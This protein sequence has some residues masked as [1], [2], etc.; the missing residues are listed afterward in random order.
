MKNSIFYKTSLFAVLV[1]LLIVP[2][3][4]NNKVFQQ[5]HKFE[6][7]S[8]NRFNYL[9]FE[10]PIEETGGEYDI[11]IAIRHLP[12]IPYKKIN[13]SLTINLPYGEMR[14][15]NHTLTMKDKEGKNLGNCLGDLCDITIPVRKGFKFAEPGIVKFDIENK[16]SKMEM[17]GIMEIGLIIRKAN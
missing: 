17:P 15:A 1:S 7:L 11:L 2:S 13:I 6:N 14:T 3:C 10:V 8:W 9:T 16:Y 5:Y 12:E 4:S